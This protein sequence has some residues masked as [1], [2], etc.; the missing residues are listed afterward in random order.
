MRRRKAPEINDFRGYRKRPQRDSNR[1]SG[2]RQNLLRNAD[3]ALIT[4]ES[5]KKVRPVSFPL[6]SSLTLSWCRV[7]AT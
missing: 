4:P 3:L 6:V 5:L 7:G 1:Y 2:V